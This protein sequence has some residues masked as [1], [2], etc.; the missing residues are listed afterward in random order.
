MWLLY[1]PAMTMI[2]TLVAVLAVIAAVVGYVGWRDRRRLSSG[3][4]AAADRTGQAQAHRQSAE[5]HGVQG[6]ID[7]NRRQDGGSGTWT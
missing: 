5:A 7:H 4:D 6:A 2:W 3:D 1:P